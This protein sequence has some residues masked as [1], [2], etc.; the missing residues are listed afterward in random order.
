M[1]KSKELNLM[2]EDWFCVVQKLREGGQKH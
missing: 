1:V 2:I